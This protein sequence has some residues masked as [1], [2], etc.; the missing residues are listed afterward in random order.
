MSKRARDVVP[1]FL[2]GVAA[3]VIAATGIVA[4]TLTFTEYVLAEERKV[5]ER[6]TSLEKDVSE[7]RSDVDRLKSD[8]ST[9]QT[10][11][12]TIKSGIQTLLATRTPAG[13]A[14]PMPSSQRAAVR[15]S[16]AIP[17]YV[18]IPAPFFNPNVLTLPDPNK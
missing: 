17:Y 2:S 8:V 3:T 13:N 16:A 1:K 12:A 5:S 9:I 10:D 18:L 15:G 7:I 11:V 6:V 4:L 14:V